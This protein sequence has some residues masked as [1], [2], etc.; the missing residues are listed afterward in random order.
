MPLIELLI[1]A[2]GGINLDIQAAAPKTQRCP[3]GSVRL[4]TDKCIVFPDH[5]Y[6][7][8]HEPDRRDLTERWWC[9]RSKK[10]NE[11][12]ISVELRQADA[13]HNDLYYVSRLTNLSVNGRK[14][15][16]RLLQEV[17]SKVAGMGQVVQ[18][19]MRCL[20]TP[21]QGVIGVLSVRYRDSAEGA[22]EFELRP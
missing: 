13:D 9:G 12:R 18:V 1:L 11:V 5:R 15:S 16:A 14:P 21:S 2:A 19:G 17:G 3:D 10:P 20:N 6:L 7:L 22:V 8:N 4:A